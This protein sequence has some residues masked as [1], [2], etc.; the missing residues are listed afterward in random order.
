MHTTLHIWT[1]TTKEN[2]SKS[3]Y[4]PSMKKVARIWFYL[5]EDTPINA[6]TH[7][8]QRL[9]SSAP[10]NKGNFPSSASDWCQ[11]LFSYFRPSLLTDVVMAWI[12]TT[13]QSCSSLAYK[14]GLEKVETII[15]NIA[16]FGLRNFMGTD[17]L[18]KFQILYTV[19]RNG[20]VRIRQ[21]CEVFSKFYNFLR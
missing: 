9:H 5:L 20:T 7:L 14:Q 19:G 16:S 2:V 8:D 21:S 10:F 4:L 12:C 1:N 17:L 3:K 15:H 13:G 11:Y 6:I 18:L